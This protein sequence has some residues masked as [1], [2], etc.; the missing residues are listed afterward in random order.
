MVLAATA[1][2]FE[3]RG[4]EVL[5][6]EEAYNCSSQLPHFQTCTGFRMASANVRR[7]CGA[8]PALNTCAAALHRNISVA[9]SSRAASMPGGNC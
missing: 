1:E 2:P 8:L 5:S 6:L 4:F 7:Y 9:L 3:S